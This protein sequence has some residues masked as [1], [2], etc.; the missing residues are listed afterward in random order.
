MTDIAKKLRDMHALAGSRCD[1]EFSRALLEAAAE[2]ERLR[3]TLERARIDVR[4][5]V[6][7]VECRMQQPAHGGRQTLA[8][9]DAAL[10]H[11]PQREQAM[12]ELADQARGTRHGV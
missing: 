11:E 1:P 12:Q 8:L 3:A 9:I 2:I 7:L 5:A 4:A 6:D 10:G